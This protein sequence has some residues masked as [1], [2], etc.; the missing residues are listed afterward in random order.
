MNETF[1]IVGFVCVTGCVALIA[2]LVWYFAITHIVKATQETFWIA[3]WVL[4]KRGQ[5]G[6]IAAK[7]VLRAAIRSDNLM[8][9]TQ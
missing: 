3:A 2:A 5:G 9:P 7:R 1:E 6:T 8:E 4:W